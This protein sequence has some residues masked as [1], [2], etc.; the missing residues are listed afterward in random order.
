MTQR[1]RNASGEYM[2]VDSICKLKTSLGDNREDLSAVSF[3]IVP[4]MSEDIVIG[5]SGLREL[6][7]EV[8]LRKV[9]KL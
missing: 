1:L 7:L 3:H 6:G 8:E 9:R 5:M 2:D 4:G